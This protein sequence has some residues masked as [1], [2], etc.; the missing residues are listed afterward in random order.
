MDTNNLPVKAR[1]AFG[2]V[3]TT[4]ALSEVCLAAPSSAASPEARVTLEVDNVQTSGTLPFLTKTG[5]LR[6]SNYSDAPIENVRAVLKKGTAPPYVVLRGRVTLPN[7]NAG[8]SAE[9]AGTFSLRLDARKRSSRSVPL[10]FVVA[11]SLNGKRYRIV[12]SVGLDVPE[13]QMES[14]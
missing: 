11:F 2:V 4:L 12:R 10:N 3:V 13:L 8:Q 5:T 9:G 7:L 6:V 14:K 1:I